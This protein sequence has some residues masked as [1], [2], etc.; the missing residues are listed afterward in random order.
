MWLYIAC[1]AIA[2]ILGYWL[3]QAASALK[4]AVSPALALLM[5]VTFAGIPFASVVKQDGRGRFLCTLF[6]L[7]GVVAPTVA[8]GLSRFVSADP[9][10]VFGVLLVLLLPCVDYV[11]TFTGIAGGNAAALLAATPLLLVAQILMLPVYLWL[12]IGADAAQ[13]AITPALLEAFGLVVLL[14]MLVALGL[15]LVARQTNG[16]AAASRA[17][18]RGGEAA[19]VPV[20][21]LNLV[22]IVY[23]QTGT[24]QDQVIRV[25]PTLGIFVLFAALMF[26]AGIGIT[27]LMRLEVT[28]S[29]AAT[30]SGITRNSLVILPVALAL[31]ASYGLV[32]VIVVS[33]TL[34][35]I[36]AMLVCVVLVPLAI[37]SRGKEAGSGIEATSGRLESKA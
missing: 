21:M 22:L 4:V 12:L 17:L 3:P 7:N 36:L 28:A 16:P 35:E 19:M 15:Q 37:R 1:I 26:G 23:V 30:F 8:F 20:M 27:C 13:L 11:V 32:P 25:L 6:L 31:P 34:V 29:R 9:V 14:P 10:L 24:V 33:Q 18:L 2:A 5:L